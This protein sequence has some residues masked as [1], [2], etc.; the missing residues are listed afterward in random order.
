[1]AGSVIRPTVV[2]MSATLLA[3]AADDP[4]QLPVPVSYNQ[5]S[6]DYGTLKSAMTSGDLDGDGYQDVVVEDTIYWGSAAGRWSKDDVTHIQIPDVG[7]RYQPVQST[8]LWLVPNLTGPGAD[9]IVRPDL[10]AID[11]SGY[12]PVLIQVQ[13]SITHI[14]APTGPDVKFTFDYGIIGQPAVG[15]FNGDGFRDIAWVDNLDYVNLAFGH[16]DGTF[17]P[18]PTP[19]L[20]PQSTSNYSA[21]AAVPTTGGSDL[22]IFKGSLNVNGSELI[23]LPKST[24]F[25]LNRFAISTPALPSLYQPVVSVGDVDGDG[26]PDV[27]VTSYTSEKTAIISGSRFSPNKLIHDGVGWIVEDVTGDG[28]D[29]FACALTAFDPISQGLV[30]GKSSFFAASPVID[31]PIS[32]QIP[33]TSDYS[34]VSG[35]S[36][37]HYFRPLTVD[38]PTLASIAPAGLAVTKQLLMVDYSGYSTSDNMLLLPSLAPAVV[39]VPSAVAV[40]LPNKPFPLFPLGNELS[41]W[42]IAPQPI[43]SFELSVQSVPGESEDL[44]F[45]LPQSIS[46]PVVAT[47]TRGGKLFKTYTFTSGS[48]P[49]ADLQSLLYSLAYVNSSSQ[50]FPGLRSVELSAQGKVNDFNIGYPYSGRSVLA[51]AGVA[52]VILPLAVQ[53][54]QTSILDLTVPLGL[55]PSDQ[56]GLVGAAPVKGTAGITTNQKGTQLSYA[57]GA[58]ASGTEDLV[59]RVIRGGLVAAAQGPGQPARVSGTDYFTV[60]VSIGAASLA[61]LSPGRTG[62]SAVLGESIRLVVADGAPPYRFTASGGSLIAGPLV[63]SGVD[64]DGDGQTNDPGEVLLFT[65]TQAGQVGVAVVDANGAQ[66]S[67]TFTTTALPVTTLVAPTVP[68]S[69]GAIT[70]FG[71]ICP[72]TTA[73][74]ASIRALF[75]ANADATKMRGFTWNAVDQTYREL[76]AEAAGGLLPTDGVFLASRVDLGLDFTGSPLPAG[77]SILLQPSWNFVGLGPVQLTGG[78]VVRTHDLAADFTVTDLNGTALPTTSTTQAYFWDGASY[79]AGTVL[80]GGVGYWIKNVSGAPLL[81]TRKESDADSKAVRVARF[82]QAGEPPAPPTSA[83]ATNNDGAAGCGSGSGIAVLLAGLAAFLKFRWRR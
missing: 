42:G 26:S 83:R 31:R 17:T 25:L 53:S 75:S 68:T 66:V 67:L 8:T 82:A 61:L 32:E 18:G 64:L 56:V 3:V 65:P 50:P 10:I 58:G 6:L 51:I 44:S 73:G 27:A 63:T 78:Q 9:R 37:D 54:G 16:G 4:V 34:F 52:I 59:V 48:A 35:R 33:G 76:P 12:A 57:A 55:S 72:G 62:R 36:I 29:D 7:G 22:I 43:T 60:R 81:L 11:H 71:P 77:T 39:S 24:P 20:L 2:L 45:V 14:S 46:A 70:V 69:T 79:N 30:H 74:V 15:D 5:D 38:V 80:T 40:N 28:I 49:R 21:V 1:M 41:D 19:Y 13:R 47:T 23:F